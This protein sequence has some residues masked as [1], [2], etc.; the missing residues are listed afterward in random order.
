MICLLARRQLRAGCIKWLTHH[1]VAQRLDWGGLLK[2]ASSRVVSDRAAASA[3]QI[4]LLGSIQQSHSMRRMPTAHSMRRIGTMRQG[5]KVVLS[6]AQFIRVMRSAGFESQS[7]LR[8][9]NAVFSSYDID[10]KDRIDM[11]FFCAAYTKHFSR[12]RGVVFGH[13]FSGDRSSAA[14]RRTMNEAHALG[15][16][17]VARSILGASQSQKASGGHADDAAAAD[18]WL[19]EGLFYRSPSSVDVK[20][21]SASSHGS[22]SSASGYGKRPTTAGAQRTGQKR[23]VRARPLSAAPT[24]GSRV[25]FA[26]PKGGSLASESSGDAKAWD[27]DEDDDAAAPGGAHSRPGSVDANGSGSDSRASPAPAADAT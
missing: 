5:G 22:H 2:K 16:E 26:E 12:K 19:A 17:E 27:P 23:G 18:D 20:R 11:S 13:E 15:G 7:D 14:D 21:G 8:H 4:N 25:R 6:R 24:R 9:V 1:P 10:V 3:S